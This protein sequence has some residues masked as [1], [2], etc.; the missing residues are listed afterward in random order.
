MTDDTELDKL[1]VDYGDNCIEDKGVYTY[2]VEELKAAILNKYIAKADVVAAIGEDLTH[3]DYCKY[4]VVGLCNCQS[5]KL[6]K[7]KTTLRKELN[8]GGDLF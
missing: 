6:N 1:L 8:V 4:K 5:L 3:K 7:F 2:R